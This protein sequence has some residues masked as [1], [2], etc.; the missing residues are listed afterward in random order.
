MANSTRP[1]KQIILELETMLE[2]LKAIGIK[3][4]GLTLGE[5]F[6]LLYELKKTANEKPL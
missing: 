3:T 4:E 2:F 5:T 1:A 6:T